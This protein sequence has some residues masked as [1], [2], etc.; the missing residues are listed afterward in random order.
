MKIDISPDK[1]I[2]DLKKQFHDCFP[3]LKIEFFDT[4]HAFQNQVPVLK[5]L[6]MM[7][8]LQKQ[9]V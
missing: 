6:A 4:S 7:Q 3:Y 9:P 8:H 2:K 5:W 1:R